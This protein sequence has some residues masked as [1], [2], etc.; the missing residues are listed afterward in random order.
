MRCQ[1][2]KLFF[3]LSAITPFEKHIV[4]DIPASSVPGGVFLEKGYGKSEE[5][6]R[7]PADSSQADSLSESNATHLLS[8][9]SG[10]DSVAPKGSVTGQDQAQRHSDESFLQTLPPE[11]QS[12]LNDKLMP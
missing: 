3:S 11:S 2:G 7:I 1:K 10:F 8:R 12:Q 4:G 9:A 5:P 6:S